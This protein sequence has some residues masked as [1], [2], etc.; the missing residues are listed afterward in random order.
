MHV[1]DV[2]N[3]SSTIGTFVDI[4][5][6][7]MKT[8]S[9]SA[10][11]NDFAPIAS[12][13]CDS[14]PA[15]PWFIASVCRPASDRLLRWIQEE[16]PAAKVKLLVN[17]DCRIRIDVEAPEKVGI[18]R[19]LGAVA[20]N[21]LRSAGRPA[22]VVDAGSAITVDAVSDAGSFLGGV[23]MAGFAMRTRA[24]AQD[25]DVLP[26]IHATG[27]DESPPIIGRSTEA[28]IR[29]GIFWGTVGSI[30][31][32]IRRIQTEIGDADVFVTGGDM[33]R[34]TDQLKETAQFVPNLVL[35]G[36]AITVREH[37]EWS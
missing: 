14:S 10:E 16:Y 33:I 1:V 3:T 21:R 19:I 28:A 17:N 20:A 12:A 13:V 23:I 7:P 2:G 6:S 26:R 5:A 27:A 9:V 11:T 37:G 30:R 24:L 29:S 31:E 25:T 8:I 22:I 18:D 15:S 34:M 35:S 4:D 36:I 32:V